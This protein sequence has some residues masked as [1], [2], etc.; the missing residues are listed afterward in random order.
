MLLRKDILGNDINYECMGCAIGK[1]K[2][3]LPGGV[4][5]KG[6]SAVLAADPEI[7]IP[8]F[9]VITCKRHI[10]SFSEL[11][12]EERDEI[13]DI[14]ALAE[15]AIK[16]LQVSQELTLVQEERSKH[17][18]IWIFPTYDWM[19]EKYGRGITFLREIM[20]YSK[21]HATKNDI[22]SV[23]DTVQKLKVYFEEHS[24]Q[25]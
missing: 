24:S 7:P 23:I 18:H 1:G 12:K 11:N 4:I 21:E 14:I 22:Q 25:M 3:E 15:K 13:G 17:L 16:E 19:V 2:M 10:H 6:R 20:E 9:L 8:G 5:Y